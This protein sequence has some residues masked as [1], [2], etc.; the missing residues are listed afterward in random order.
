MKLRFD[1]RSLIKRRLTVTFELFVFA[2]VSTEY[3]IRKASLVERQ[4]G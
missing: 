3:G 4:M 2:G 1:Y